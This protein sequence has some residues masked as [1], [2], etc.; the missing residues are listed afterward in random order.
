[1][2]RQ[3]RQCIILGEV[4]P[5]DVLLVS[6][7]IWE[8]LRSRL[9]GSPLGHRLSLSFCRAIFSG[10]ADSK[11]FTPDVLDV[12]FWDALLTEMSKLPADNTLCSLLVK[13]MAA[14]PAIYRSSVSDGVLSVLGRFFSVWGCSKHAP[15]NSKIKR[16]LD[17]GRLGLHADNPKSL[18][19]LPGYLRQARVLSEA[20]HGFTPEGTDGFLSAAHRLALSTKADLQNG[21][22]A[23]R[24]SWLYV[25]AQMPNV[26]Q[27]FLFDAAVELS[28]P[29][30]Q[31]TKPLTSVELCS[32]LLTQWASRGYLPLQ[33]TVYQS[34][35]KHCFCDPAALASLFVA[36][37]N[38]VAPGTAPPLF[39]SAWRFL[40]KL[41]QK[42]EVVGSLEFTVAKQSRRGLDRRQIP[43]RMLED[44]AWTSDDH[45]IAIA[46]CNLW[47][48]RINTE[49]KQPQFYPGVFVKY[50]E[51][52]VNDRGLPPSTI[53]R[54]MDIHRFEGRQ[55]SLK[56]KLRHHRGTFGVRR[57]VVAERVAAAFEGAHHLTRRSVFRHASQGLYF[58]RAIKGKVPRPVLRIMYRLI[59]QDLWHESPGI[60]KRLLWWLSLVEREYGIDVAWACR[61]KLREW[62][63][64]LARQWLDKKG[65][66]H[67]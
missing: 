2:C 12:R 48:N 46:L 50:I 67:D 59:T 32:L 17:V 4:S 8:T 37:F 1:M 42:N 53:W 45:N 20:L 16:L 29:S 57:A 5:E 35:R 62:R 65:I 43:V 66:R 39:R 22:R 61:L 23:L 21:R 63:K 64:R 52:I 51:D 30:S 55:T 27:D 11:V 49:D 26:N 6:V 25:L 7:E 33:H 9:Q 10:L 24:Y 58:I 3:L 47:R 14:V 41:G 15:K 60:T 56:Y 40:T 38:H 54:I 19:A 31:I 36:I 28:A 34:Y 18:S 44:L 13:V